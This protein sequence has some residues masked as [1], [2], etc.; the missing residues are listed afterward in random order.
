MNKFLIKR[1]IV[2][3]LLGFGITQILAAL[4]GFF[5]QEVAGAWKPYLSTIV[6]LSVNG[7]LLLALWLWDRYQRKR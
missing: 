2:L 5:F 3:L 1:A 6:V 7:A 4:L